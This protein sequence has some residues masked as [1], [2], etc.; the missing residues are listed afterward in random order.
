MERMFVLRKVYLF[1]TSLLLAIMLGISSVFAASIPEGE[2]RV[3]MGANLDEQQRARIYKD[4]D[5]VEGDVKELSVTNQEER[6]YLEGVAPESKIG[7]VA[8]S[9]VYI[10]TLEQDSGLNISLHNINWCSENMYRNAL[11][12]AGIVDAS[13]MISA[14]FPVSGTAA[15]TGIYKAY[16][17]ITGEKLDESA[18]KAAANELVITGDLAEAMG[19]VDATQ[20]VNELKGILDQTKDMTDDEVRSEI[21]KI[22]KDLG[23]E[24]T[25]SQVEQLLGLC[26]ELEGLDT[27]ELQKRLESIVGTIESV[28]KVDTFFSKLGKDIQ[29]FFKSIGNFF[30]NLFHF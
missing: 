6:A 5:L 9:C 28:Q 10:K 27:E 26:R 30:S 18:K 12:T 16:E 2:S 11:I 8:L 29:T 7:N 22:A 13:V 17:D 23:V 15:L 14:P 1:I 3:A 4:F 24:I 21:R 25:D 20:L 19:S